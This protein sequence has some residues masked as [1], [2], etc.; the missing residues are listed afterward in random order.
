MAIN[1]DTSI[2]RPKQGP[3]PVPEFSGIGRPPSCR[4]PGTYHPVSVKEFAL[5]LHR[6]R[7]KT[8]TLTRGRAD[9]SKVRAAF[10][11]IRTAR[12]AYN[13]K[14]PGQEQWLII[15]WP[16]SE[17]EPTDYYLSNLPKRTRPKRLLELSRLRWRVERDYQ[18][19]KQEVGLEHHEGR[20]WVGFHHHLTLC[21][22]A[23]AFLASQ[24]RLFP[25]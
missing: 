23:H 18:D 4:L 14:E 1:S 12:G 3:D 8:F 9:P 19:M 17:S 24:R 21:M 11:R 25:P 10:A 6:K 2:W 13:G 7:F 5:G 16:P 15:V 22:A 20:N